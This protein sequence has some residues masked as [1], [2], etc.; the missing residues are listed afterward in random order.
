M[1]R[2][3][4]EIKDLFSLIRFINLLCR[5]YLGTAQICTPSS[6]SATSDAHSVA[7]L[8]LIKPQTLIFADGFA[9][10]IPFS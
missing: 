1:Q 2:D 5:Y 4:A 10:G 9:V 7:I 6:S 3:K 8:W